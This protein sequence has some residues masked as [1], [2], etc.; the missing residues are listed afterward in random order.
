[1]TNDTSYVDNKWIVVRSYNEFVST[2]KE[3]FGRNYFP[4]LISFDNDLGYEIPEDEKTGYDCAKWVV[5]FC[6]DNNLELPKYKVHSQNPVGQK[7]ISSYLANYLK[8]SAGARN[9]N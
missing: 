7:N 1:M 9:K 5:D 6:I 8:H 2:I 4:L 3:M